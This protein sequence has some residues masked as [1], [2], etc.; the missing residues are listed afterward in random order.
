MDQNTALGLF[1]VMNEHY[2]TLKRPKKL[3]LHECMKILIC[4]HPKEDQKQTVNTF[5]LHWY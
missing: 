5:D 4:L 3:I 1:F 2:N